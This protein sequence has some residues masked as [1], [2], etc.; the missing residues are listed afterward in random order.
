MDPVD[1]GLY[2]MVAVGFLLGLAW[3]YLGFRIRASHRPLIVP[4]WCVGLQNCALLGAM[5]LPG[6]I[7]F[8]YRD[9]PDWR[10]ALL[11]TGVAILVAVNFLM[12]RGYYILGVD[13]DSVRVFVRQYLSDRG[14][15]FEE[16]GVVFAFGGTLMG[17]KV[18][19]SGRSGFARAQ[20]YPMSRGGLLREPMDELRRLYG[21]NPP[22]LDPATFRHAV[23]GGFALIAIGGLLLY[24]AHT[25]L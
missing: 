23:G 22:A 5:L 17:A 3:I 6:L 9:G 11:L 7:V 19:I 24:L 18:E 13:S 20:T 12:N 14:I 8:V 1:I 4:G 10:S 25:L 2:A 16:Q 21:T 15:A